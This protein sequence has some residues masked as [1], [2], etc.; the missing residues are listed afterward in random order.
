MARRV[1]SF[2]SQFKRDLKKYYLALASTEWAEVLYYL[3]NDKP[4]PEKYC[5]HPLSGEWRDC[6]DCHVRPDLLLI[7]RREGQLLQLLRLGS[8]SEIF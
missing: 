3:S 5:D 8:H 4:L 6:R 1:V 2:S 7:Y